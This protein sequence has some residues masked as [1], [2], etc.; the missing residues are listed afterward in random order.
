VATGPPLPQTGRSLA[1]YFLE[2]G[3]FVENLRQCGHLA[4]FR[5]EKMAG[6]IQS[7]FHSFCSEFHENSLQ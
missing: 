2:K 4:I 5:Q 6:P 1:N 7:T 3:I